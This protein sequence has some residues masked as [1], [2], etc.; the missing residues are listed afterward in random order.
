MRITGVGVEQLA[1]LARALVAEDA[2]NSIPASSP[3]SLCFGLIGT[4]GAGKT[5]FCQ[6]IASA[7]RIDPAEVTSPTFTLIKS[8]PIA[9]VGD[10]PA[11]TIQLHHLDL[12]RIVDE[13]EL[14]ELGMDE[15]WE[16]PG[17]WILMEWADRF[18]DCLPADTIWV[19]IEIPDDSP[20]ANA[21]SENALG[22]TPQPRRVIELQ[23]S[24]PER[25][26]WLGNVESRLRDQGI[27]G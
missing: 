21:P 19:R 12:Y 10:R 11:A 6:E 9:A 16:T 20:L 13:D 17:A 23:S 7:W 24:D 27:I 26:A 25:Q 15:L 22:N 5:R 2:E 8:Y 1:Q 18:A 4:L 3:R 14:W